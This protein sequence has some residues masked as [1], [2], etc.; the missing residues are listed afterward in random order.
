MTN[1]ELLEMVSKLSTE[2]VDTKKVLAACETKLKDKASMLT[3][4]DE[5]MTEAEVPQMHVVNRLEWLIDK[6]AG[7]DV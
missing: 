7:K 3:H 5:K 6:A 1:E 2:L 4:L